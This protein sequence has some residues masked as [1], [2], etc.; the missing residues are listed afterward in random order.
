MTGALIRTY[1]ERLNVWSD[2]QG[3]LQFMHDLVVDEK[4]EDVV[5]LGVRDGNSTA[6]LMA[7]IAETGGHLWSVDT[8]P[9]TPHPAWANSLQWTFIC[10]ND[11]EVVNSDWMPLDI[12]ICFIDTVHW[13]Q[14]TL[15]ELVAYGPRSKIILLHDTELEHPY[16]APPGDPPFPVRRAIEEWLENDDDAT[17]RTVEWRT[18][19]YGMAVIR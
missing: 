4:A 12:D 1:Q 17:N 10:G 2:I 11:L 15:A 5:E 13:Y 9:V 19:S 8:V 14:H 3:H 16:M 7:G 18:G 6:A